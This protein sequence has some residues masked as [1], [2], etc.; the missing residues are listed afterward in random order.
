M[1]EIF[2]NHALQLKTS[3]WNRGACLPTER[4][5]V[6]TLMPAISLEQDAPKPPPCSRMTFIQKGLKSS[7]K[8]LDVKKWTQEPQSIR[9]TRSRGID[10]LNALAFN[11]ELSTLDWFFHPL[12]IAWGGGVS[13]RAGKGPSKAS[14]VLIM[15]LTRLIDRFAAPECSHGRHYAGEWLL[16]KITE[17]GTLLI[18]A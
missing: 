4:L 14:T 2:H 10:G 13:Q 16:G 11:Q 1:C 15:K 7:D 3:G 5:G 17:K 8:W 12:L 18:T 6:Q 9:P